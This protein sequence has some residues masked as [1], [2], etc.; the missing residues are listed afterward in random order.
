M[1]QRYRIGDRVSDTDS[2]DLLAL[3]KRHDEAEEKI[4]CGISY[5]IVENAPEPH[6]EQRCFWIVRSNY[7]KIDISYQH[8][9]EK[10]LMTK[11]P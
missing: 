1:L 8:C 4:G 11:C 3:M 2:L 7:S 9:L 5:F 10:S 6:P